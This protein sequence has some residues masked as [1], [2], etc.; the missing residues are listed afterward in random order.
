[1]AKWD[2]DTLNS[3][4]RKL[5]EFLR[6]KKAETS[7]PPPHWFQF[8]KTGLL[9]LHNFK[10]HEYSGQPE[11]E[12]VGDRVWSIHYRSGWIDAGGSRPDKKVGGFLDGICDLAISLGHGSLGEGHRI[13]A[14]GASRLGGDC[15]I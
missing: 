11:R 10:A 9:N 2:L 7:C 14:Q 6:I 15:G 3:G 4:I 13:A 8:C 1:M 5:P 12:D